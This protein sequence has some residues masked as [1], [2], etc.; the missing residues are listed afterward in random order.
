MRP[1]CRSPPSASRTRFRSSQ[2]KRSELPTHMMPAMTC[3]HRRSTSSSSRNACSII[4]EPLAVQRGSSRNE[5]ERSSSSVSPVASA[6]LSEMAPHAQ[7]AQEEVEQSLARRGVV[8]HVPDER[9]LRGLRDE[10]RQARRRRGERLEIEGVHGG[11]TRDELGRV[12]VPS[13]VEAARQRVPDV[14]RLE[15]PR[16][17]DRRDGRRPA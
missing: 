6:S 13:L 2:L 8:E 11:V 3:I 14:A 10:V 1:R 4:R 12:Q 16:G 15:L 9:R 5:R 7:P 17:V